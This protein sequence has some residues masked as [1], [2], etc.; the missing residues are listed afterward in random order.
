[1]VM[2]SLR[3]QGDTREAEMQKTEDSDGGV[4]PGETTQPIAT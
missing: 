3:E 1:M 2:Q 4:L